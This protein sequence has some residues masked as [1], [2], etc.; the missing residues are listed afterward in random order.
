VKILH[1]TGD[2]K[3]TGPAEP[4]LNAVLGLRARGHQVDV[5]FPL[6]PEGHAGLVERARERGVEPLLR[7]VRRQGYLPLRD[8]AELR[9]L[10]ALLARGGY[11]VVH[12]HHTRDH[13]LA[14][15]A[16]RGLP[17]RLVA[18]WHHG[19]P[20]PDRFWNRWLLGPRGPHGLVVL[21]ERVAAAARRE[22]GWPEARVA[23]VPGSVDAERFAPRPRLAALRR[24]LGL[25]VTERVI[26]L[27][28]RLQPH[29]RVDLLL[30]AFERALGEAPEL[31][32]VVVG[33]G[34]RAR[35]VLE[36]PVAAR[37]LGANV[38]RAGYRGADYRDVLALFDALVF[39]VP[40]SDGSC[41]AVLEAMALEIPVIASPRGV[42]P[43]TV[44][45]GETGRIVPEDPD[46]LA[47][48]FVDL[49]REPERW[50]AL[51]KAARRRVLERHTPA[52]AAERLESL[53]SRL[54]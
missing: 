12:V 28:A 5:A 14:R 51:G 50:R 10:R 52:L 16:L 49:R 43:D 13:M 42:L 18:S 23:V 47:A 1:L 35:E 24:E 53:Y 17:S 2:W 4:M 46:A 48:A 27:V 44:V 9:R 36:Q 33:R 20:I 32:L 6:P 39:L 34:T 40:G 19:D 8:C 30:E 31:R 25:G 21:G 26:G 54:V 45:D 41:R 3:W 29:R 22:L 11:D 15:R 7:L 38:I 37:G